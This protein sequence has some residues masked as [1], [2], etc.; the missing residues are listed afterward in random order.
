MDWQ[1]RLISLFVYI[2]KHYENY[3]WVYGE[4]LSPN[5]RPSFN[6]PEV[7]T[8]YIWG[9]WRGHQEI[10]EIDQYTQDH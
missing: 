6:D 1:E 9:V 5:A 2:S 10:Q 7:L 3:L 8:I 4:R